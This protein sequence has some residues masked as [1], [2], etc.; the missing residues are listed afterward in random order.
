MSDT[1]T[2]YLLTPDKIFCSDPNPIANTTYLDMSEEDDLNPTRGTIVA[3]MAGAVSSYEPYEIAML[4]TFDSREQRA[5]WVQKYSEQVYQIAVSNTLNQNRVYNKKCAIV[6]FEFL[7]NSY[8]NGIQTKLTLKLFGKWQSSLTEL[9]INTGVYSGG[10]KEYTRGDVSPHYYVYDSALAYG[11]TTYTSKIELETEAGFVMIAPSGSGLTLTMTSAYNGHLFQI[12]S[13]YANTITGLSTDFVAYPS[14]ATSGIDMFK[15]LD[16]GTVMT[17]GWNVEMEE[18]PYLYDMF[19]H[20]QDYPISVGAI[21]QTG[22]SVP[23]A[24]YIYTTQDFI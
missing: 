15:M 18:L 17:Y 21:N 22:V 4:L 10:T 24:V 23:V 11:S 2:F 6:S 19:N 8:I 13:R 12:E 7:E 3:G 14:T 20:A 1:R 5:E 16:G 9:E